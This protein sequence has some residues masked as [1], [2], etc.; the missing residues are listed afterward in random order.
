MYHHSNHRGD[1]DASDHGF[2]DGPGGFGHLVHSQR[3]LH[4]SFLLHVKCEM[5]SVED[6]LLNLVPSEA[7]S[8]CLLLVV[9]G[10][11]LLL[12]AVSRAANTNRLYVY[13]KS[14]H[15][16]HKVGV[17]GHREKHFGTC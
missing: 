5:V 2:G 9:K 11:F 10:K 3:D 1:V 8:L 16:V 14:T 13:L 4:A 12:P 7:E 6:L 15:H 17:E